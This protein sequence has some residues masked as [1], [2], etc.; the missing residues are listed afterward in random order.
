[1]DLSSPV[2]RAALL[3]AVEGAGLAAL[4]VLYA[5]RGLVGQPESVLGTE[6]GAAITVLT[7]AGLLAVARGLAGV[8]PWSRSPAVVVQLLALPVGYTLARVGA[9]AA[10]VPVLLLAGAVLWQ[11]A[12]PAARAAFSET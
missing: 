6:L 5:V 4:G 10:A 3:V 7:G 2:R 1:M 12:T 9:W 8:R 11:L